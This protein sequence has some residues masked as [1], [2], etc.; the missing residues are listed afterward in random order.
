LRNGDLKGVLLLI[1]EQTESIGRA[2]R[3]AESVIA[4]LNLDSAADNK[5][6]PSGTDRKRLIWRLKYPKHK[7]KTFQACTTD[8]SQA[9]RRIREYV[10]RRYAVMGEFCKY[11]SMLR[12]RGSREISKHS[13]G[14]PRSAANFED[15][16]LKHNTF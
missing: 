4:K 16:D 11:L 5:P 12:R 13:A 6:D 2:I 1:R 7:S 8:K 15:G 3:S 9:R 14:S 10:L